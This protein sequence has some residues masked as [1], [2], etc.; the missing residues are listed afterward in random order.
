MI[1]YIDEIP[2][3]I[4]DKIIDIYNIIASEGSAEISRLKEDLAKSQHKYYASVSEPCKHVQTKLIKGDR[5]YEVCACCNKTIGAY[6]DH[7]SMVSSPSNKRLVKEREFLL[8]IHHLLK[9]FDATIGYG[10]DG[11]GVELM[12]NGRTVFFDNIAETE[13]I[14]SIIEGI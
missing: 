11:D 5:I 3:S 9:S 14:D 8:A 12:V 2:D 6:D 13:D 1:D 10:R 4:S 7:I